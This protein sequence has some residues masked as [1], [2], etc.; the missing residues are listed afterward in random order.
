MSRGLA[1]E[2]DVAVEFSPVSTQ[3]LQVQFHLLKVLEKTKVCFFPVQV[4]GRPPFPPALRP[5]VGWDRP[6][7]PLLGQPVKL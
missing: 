4:P 5:A 3:A 1:A 2:N 6:R 7:G